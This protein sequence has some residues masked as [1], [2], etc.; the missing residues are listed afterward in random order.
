MSS[1]QRI[2]VPIDFSENASHALEWAID[3]ARDLGAEI[4]LLHAYATSPNLGVYGVDL[5][6]TLEEDV[7]RAAQK[8][9]AAVAHDVAAKGIRVREHLARED[10][11]VAIAEQA[12]MLGSDLI[13][14]G[15]RGLGGFQHL[16]LGSVT[17]RTIRHAPCPVL[18]VKATA[19]K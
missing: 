10:P 7:R 18:S 11:S 13:V 19:P 5:P 14:M 6:G 16:L 4:D 1:I 3:F 8:Q 17:E 2:L 15:T 9:L 12:Q